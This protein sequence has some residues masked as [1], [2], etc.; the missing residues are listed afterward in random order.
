MIYFFLKPETESLKLVQSQDLNGSYRFQNCKCCL[1]RTLNLLKRDGRGLAAYDRIDKRADFRLLPLVLGYQLLF[2]L[3]APDVQGDRTEVGE[4]ARAAA[5]EDL[6]LFLRHA[7]VAVGE[8]GDRTDGAVLVRHRHRKGIIEIA[9][10]LHGGS[11]DGNRQRC[12]HPGEEIHEVADPADY[13]A[14]DEIRILNP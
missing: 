8:I 9:G 3:F 1:P 7:L 13:P 5:R 2:R 14:A 10:S 4:D 6:H 12:V 11:I